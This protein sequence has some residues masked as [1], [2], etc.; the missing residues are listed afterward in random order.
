MGL[1]IK[2]EILCYDFLWLYH[3]KQKAS[4]IV[5]NRYHVIMFSTKFYSVDL[6]FYITITII[7]YPA[8]HHVH[9]PLFPLYTAE[10]AGPCHGNL[11]PCK[12]TPEHVGEKIWKTL[13]NSRCAGAL[14]F[15][16]LPGNQILLPAPHTFRIPCKV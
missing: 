4:N 16:S 1:I 13:D 6:L 9:H 15:L 12:Q 7:N 2:F 8:Q 11:S 14:K 5:R 3:F 10:F